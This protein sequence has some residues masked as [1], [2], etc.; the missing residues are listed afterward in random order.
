[1][2]PFKRV[3]VGLD[4]SPL[5]RKVLE[6]MAQL[7]TTFPIDT[8]YALH[9]VPG[10]SAPRLPEGDFVAR[11]IQDQP[12]DEVLSER[13]QQQVR[14]IFGDQPPFTIKVEVIE[15]KP[16]DQIIHWAEVKKADLLVLGRKVLSDGSGI[17]AKRVA[18]QAN[19]PVLF[20]TETAR[21]ARNIVVPID[22]SE[23]SA[24]A[25]MTAL[26]RQLLF[27]DTL[28]HALHIVEFPPND[29]YMLPYKEAGFRK[30]LHDSAREAFDKFVQDYHFPTDKIQPV[31]RENI[32]QNPAKHILEYATEVHADLI[33]TGARGHSVFRNMLFGS[34]TEALIEQNQ[35]FPLLI[36]R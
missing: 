5:D 25:L 13:I 18:R 15:G 7:H 36:V 6:Y 12:L 22:Y 23:F 1:M 28:I 35:G 14:A 8:L 26:D 3:V 19:C 30:I 24:R 10:F 9:I 29:Y 11:F 32:L 33:L 31:Y 34:V 17:V 27:P 16:S 21:A 20:V 2:A 4:F